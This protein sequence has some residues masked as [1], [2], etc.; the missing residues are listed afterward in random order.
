MRNILFLLDGMAPS[1]GHFVQAAGLGTSLETL[2]SSLSLDLQ[3][4]PKIEDAM[5]A[6]RINLFGASSADNTR[7]QYYI[8]ELL[9]DRT[10]PG[11]VA[12]NDF[13][14]YSPGTVGIF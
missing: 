2:V 8:D 5:T 12:P 14:L 13:I 7:H 6:V 9:N 1:Y 3:H 10:A 11:R 4:L